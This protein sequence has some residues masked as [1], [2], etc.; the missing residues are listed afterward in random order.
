IDD[1]ALTSTASALVRQVGES[2]GSYNITAGTFTAHSTNY[3]AP[4]YLGTPKLTITPVSLN[5]AANPQSKVTGTPD[6]ALTFGVARLVNNPALG[7]ADTT[8]SVLSGALTRI[9]GESASG[10]P[11]AITQGSL[12]ANSNYTLGFTPNN[13]IITGAPV[14][15]VSGFNPVQI[16]SSG[17]ITTETYYR[18][19]NVWHISLDQNNADRGFD[20]MRGTTDLNSRLKRSLPSCGSVSW[21]GGL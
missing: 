4:S 6:P 1:G 16:G 14:D 8:G 13:L 3:N 10:G 19:G 11:Y 20:V 12:L 5:V 7:I 21:G 18:P 17:V 9:P 15:T 2:V